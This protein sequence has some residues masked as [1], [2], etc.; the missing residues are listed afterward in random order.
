ME[1][2]KL[3][4]PHSVK[5]ENRAGGTLTGVKKLISAAPNAIELDT[6][7]GGM[8]VSGADLKLERYDE[9][10][11]MLTFSG[12]VGAIKYTGAKVPLLKRL[13]K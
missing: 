2:K 1:E 4:K 6:H 10:E 9:A 12:S 13:F 3:I 5:I 7:G 8:T 11:G